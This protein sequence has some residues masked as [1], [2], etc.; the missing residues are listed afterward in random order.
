MS[1]GPPPPLAEAVI[2][3]ALLLTSRDSALVT[4]ALSEPVGASLALCAVFVLGSW[5]AALATGYW[6]YVDRLWSI[7][8]VVFAG[9]FV[10][11]APTHPRLALMFALA[12]VWGARLTVNFARKVSGRAFP[13]CGLT[14]T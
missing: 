1:S 6:S 13:R 12:F 7:T 14:P 10:A 11:F 9:T 4:A 3:A 2:N 5:L 8:P